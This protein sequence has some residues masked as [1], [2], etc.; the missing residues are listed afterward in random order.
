MTEMILQHIVLYAD[1]RGWMQAGNT[2]CANTVATD[3][4]GN[5]WSKF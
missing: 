4:A 3:W 1:E 5:Y 2:R